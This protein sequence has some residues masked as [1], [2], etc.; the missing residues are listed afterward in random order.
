MV[1]NAVNSLG[2]TRTDT[3]SPGTVLAVSP[4][5]TYVVISD[6]VRQVISLENSSGTVVST[7][8]ASCTAPNC[9]A[10]FSPDSQTL[11]ISAGNQILVWSTF[12]GWTQIN[13]ATSGGTSVTDVAVTVPSVG[14]YFAGPI[15]TARSYCPISTQTGATTESNVFYPAADSSPAV[16]DRLA[17]TNDGKHIL[18]ASITPAPTLSDLRVTI[19]TGACPT[20]GS[21]TFS[22]TLSTTLLSSITASSITGVWPTSD[23]SIAFITY[24]GSGGA[25]PA[26]VP[27]SSGSGT[28][29]YIKLSGNAVAPVSGVLSAD[30]TTFYTGTTGDNLVHLINRSTLTDSSTLAPNLT[31]PS[32]AVVPVD[33]LVQKPRKT[34]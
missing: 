9:R 34:T 13:P 31:N 2:I 15:T 7:Y 26:Y 8:G 29:S 24:S 32:G 33:L 11:Y 18:G 25:I 17:A 20:T 14:A 19:P 27:A 1:L 4:D 3:T 10:E 23:S 22:S 30:N 28:L 16:T 5:N 6:P 21:L 12:T